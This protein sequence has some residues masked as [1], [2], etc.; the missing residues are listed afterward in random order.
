MDKLPDELLEL[1][2]EYVITDEVPFCMEDCLR[3]LMEARA[4]TCI[5]PHGNSTTP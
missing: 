5:T 3:G 4:G 1:I 2:L